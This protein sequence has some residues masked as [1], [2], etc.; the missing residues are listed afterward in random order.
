LSPV[1][2]K[3]RLQ[4]TVSK[5]FHLKVEVERRKTCLWKPSRASCRFLSEVVFSLSLM[6][7]AASWLVAVS[8]AAVAADSASVRWLVASLA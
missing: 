3:K 2:V 8:R 7:A 6:L 5:L 1:T 4:H